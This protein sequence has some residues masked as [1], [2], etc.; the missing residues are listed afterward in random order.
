MWSEKTLLKI[1]LFNYGVTSEKRSDT[2]HLIYRILRSTGMFSLTK[3]LSRYHPRIFMYHHISDDPLVP[4]ISS[5]EFESH[6][7][8]I[9]K[10]FNVISLDELI[11]RMERGRS[12]KNVVV[13]TF[14]DLTLYST[15]LKIYYTDT[16]TKKDIKEIVIPAKL[17]AIRNCGQEILFADSGHFDNSTKKLTLTGNVKMLKEGNVLVTDKLIYSAEFEGINSQNNAK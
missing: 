14:D 4:S 11:S 3:F 2:K 12:I 1:G 15:V 8:I 16:S 5:K 17:K 13:L 10:H 6:L 9:S 7:A